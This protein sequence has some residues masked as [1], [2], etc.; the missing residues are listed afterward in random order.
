MLQTL[1]KIATSHDSELDK[2]EVY[3]CIGLQGTCIEAHSQHVSSKHFLHEGVLSSSYC[4]NRHGVK[5]GIFIT[6]DDPVKGI[7]HHMR[8]AYEMNP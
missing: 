3:V 5:K 2:M 6:R 1:E 8:K 7:A 4:T